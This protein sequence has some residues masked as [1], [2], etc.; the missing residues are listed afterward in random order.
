MSETSLSDDNYR[1]LTDILT[2]KDGKYDGQWVVVAGGRVVHHGSDNDEMVRKT[3]V[4]QD[5]GDIPLVHYITA[6]EPGA[7]IL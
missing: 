6:K 5:G 2:S 1:C 4:I 7:F 3:K